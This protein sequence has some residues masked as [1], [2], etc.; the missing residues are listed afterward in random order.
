M[1]DVEYLRHTGDDLAIVDAARVSFDKASEY[2]CTDLQI[3]TYDLPKGD[4]K[5]INFLAKHKHKSPFNHAFVSFRVTAP[6]FTARQLVKHEYL[7]WNEVSRRY[8][9]GGLEWYWPDDTDWRTQPTNV[10][11]GSGEP[12]NP[13]IVA[14]IKARYAHLLEDAESL[15]EDAI[16]MGLCRE[17]ARMFLP[18]SLTTSW[19]WSG[20]LYA[21]AKMCALRLDSHSQRE[22]FY[23]AQPIHD[24]LMNLFP[25]SMKALMKHGAD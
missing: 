23:V 3:G 5:L 13:A 9:E 24:T 21:F 25:V 18:Q 4:Q 19:I 1:I 8:V 20:S 2:E 10:K 12:L 6:V 22:A 11:Q 14:M 7:P 15:Y 16:S 17:Q